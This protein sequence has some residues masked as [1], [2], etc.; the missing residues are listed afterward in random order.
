MNEIEEN[1][2]KI[3]AYESHDDIDWSLVT[4][5][6]TSLCLALV[7]NFKSLNPEVKIYGAVIDSGQNWE[8]N[9][10]LN[11]EEGWIEM[12]KRFREENSKWYGDKSDQEIFDSLGRW[13]YDAWKYQYLDFVF[14]G[15]HPNVNE[16][17]NGVFDAFPYEDGVYDNF[18]LSCARAFIA[19]RSSAELTGINQTEDFEIRFH[20]S[21]SLEWEVDELIA[22]AKNS[23]QGS[24]GIG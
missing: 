2:S 17:H 4:Q 12:P 24:D 11:S 9:L 23:Q 14:L 15:D 22:K 20:D 18:T 16:I 13:Y 6:L 10:H 3:E 1:L 8:L 21:N 19:V 5:N 7:R